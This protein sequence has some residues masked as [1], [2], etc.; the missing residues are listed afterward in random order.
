MNVFFKW[1]GIILAKETDFFIIN[2]GEKKG[3]KKIFR[4]I[5]LNNN[6]QYIFLFLYFLDYQQ[7]EEL[8]FLP[9]LIW[10]KSRLFHVL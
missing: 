8:E 10:K 5:F 2:G 1:R 9:K 7:K 4:N 6:S 3:G